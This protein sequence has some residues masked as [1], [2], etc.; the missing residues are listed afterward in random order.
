MN[1]ACGCCEGIEPLTP[2]TTA[3]RPGLSELAYRAGTHATFLTTM[4]ARLSAGKESALDGLTTRDAAD[5]AIALLDAWATVADVL[6]FYQERIANEGYLRTATERRSILELARLVGYTPRPG[7]AAS[8]YLGFVLETPPD[9]QSLAGI[10][11]Q[12]LPSPPPQPIETAKDSFDIPAGTR[13]Q[14]L[15]GPGEL[16]QP[17]E[18]AEIL[19]ARAAWNNLKPRT[20]EPQTI[21]SCDQTLYFEGVDTNLKPNDPILVD[22]GTRKQVCRV[23]DVEP[24]S[25]AD[26]TAVTAEAWQQPI[27]QVPRS[28]RRVPGRMP[29]GLRAESLRD[30]EAFLG[31]IGDPAGEMAEGLVQRLADALLRTFAATA[32]VPAQGTAEGAARETWEVL[33]DLGSMLERIERETEGSELAGRVRGILNWL[34]HAL[35]ILDSGSTLRLQGVAGVGDLADRLLR[36]QHPAG[37]VST[38]AIY[39]SGGFAA[40]FSRSSDATLQLLTYLQPALE[41]SFYDALR[42]LEV[43]QEAH[44]RVYAFRTRA[45]LFG[46]NAPLKPVK[47]DP[48]TGEITK[49]SEWPLDTE[50]ENTSTVFLDNAYDQILPGAESYVIVRKLRQEPE[51]FNAKAVLTRSRASYNISGNTTEITL[52]SDW[53][54]NGDGN[55]IKVIRG[56]VVYAQS[57]EL[58]LARK[59][60]DPI[61]RPVEG[62][63]IELEGLYDG[64]QR[65]RWVIVSGEIVD[66]P[67]VRGVVMSEPAMLADVQQIMPKGPGD[68]A[69]S[70]LTLVNR[71]VH[72]YKLDTVSIYGNV[73]R[74]THGETRTEVLGSGDGSQALQ[75]FSLKQSPL[76]HVAATTPTG[77]DSTLEVYVNDIRWQETERFID[78]E[79]ID[80]RFVTSTDDQDKTTL[81]FGDGEHGAR[82]PTG[83]ENVRA[84]YRTGIGK[85]GNVAAKQINQL[86]TH[87]LGLKGVINPLPAT[88]GADRE[89]RDQARRNAP[90]A[91]MTLDRLVSVRDYEDFAR[92]FAGIGKT[93]AI[94]LHD[95]HRPLVHLTIAGAD[96][97]PITRD[98]DLYRNLV[99]ALRR[100]G[101]PHQPLRVEVR[102][103]KP[104]VIRAGVRMLPDYL[105]EPVEAD[106]RVALLDT[107]GFERRELGQDALLSEVIGAIQR[108]PG[109]LYVDV[110]AFGGIPE[111]AKP[112]EIEEEM[113]KLD[114]GEGQPSSRVTADLARWRGGSIGP[115]QL[116]F[117][118]PRV[119]STLDLKEITA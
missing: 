52:T 2:L 42:A 39:P 58:S 35:K 69:H 20:T 57:E 99:G 8:V 5:P 63:S 83:M 50:Y 18:T 24:D 59:P 96:D 95:G 107:F 28:R 72:K 14:S 73:V 115:A 30:A 112:E 92:A 16:P 54:D 79:P 87:P 53:R 36:S 33:E 3:N 60:I 22:F 77:T 71:L 11:A 88:G 118:A 75:R 62:S 32:E 116:A 56:T 64:L 25:N 29:A 108:V 105:W 117:L 81:V 101:D 76:T 38:G 37:T 111:K 70:N 80:R 23:L 78:L 27:P 9:P 31:R 93:S 65:G 82:L 21:T 19:E 61:V 85:A 41:E 67:N 74:A 113:T 40:S 114:S 44:A 48:G 6:T 49:A 103:L 43:G 51:V 13:A 102:E 55:D 89:P 100:F 98:S 46:H 104:L 109:V 47:C 12:S 86:A 106:I 1:Q 4:K 91:M 84:V 17:F 45:S 7:V 26:R 90:L 110:N 97:I 68:T 119:S 94:R 66:D 15:P 10:N 34:D